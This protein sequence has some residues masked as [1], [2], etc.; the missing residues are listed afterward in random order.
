MTEYRQAQSEQ[1]NELAKAL[2]KFQKTFEDP[3]KDQTATIVSKTGSKYEYK[4]CGL[5]SIVKAVRPALAAAGICFI[6]HYDGNELITML[7]HESG[8][9][10]CGYQPLDIAA[11]ASPQDFGRIS[12]YARRYGLQAIVGCAADDDDDAAESAPAKP[13]ARKVEA[14]PEGKKPFESVEEASQFF[15]HVKDERAMNIGVQRFAATQASKFALKGQDLVTATEAGKE[16]R[17]R[18]QE[19][20]K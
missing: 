12:S 2:V 5:P 20:A 10:I 3:A 19:A 11:G 13:A 8:Q 16:A 17:E 15:A 4:Y 14:H 7:V 9:W 6:Q 1:I 18:L